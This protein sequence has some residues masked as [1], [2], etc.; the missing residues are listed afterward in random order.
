M[1]LRLPERLRGNYPL[2]KRVAAPVNIVDVFPTVLQLA[3]AAP[4]NGLPGVSLLT[5]AR[6]RAIFSEYHAQGM[7]N[8]GYMLKYG[9]YKLCY[10]VN[11][12][13]Q[14]F[15]LSN[16]PEETHDLHGAGQYGSV[17]KA[18]TGMLKSVCDPEKRDARA[19]RNQQNR[20]A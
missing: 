10:Y 1:I 18:M 11:G 19:K 14:L 6:D 5:P 3:G 4:V 12:E 16:D 15:D 7:L 2:E 20:L 13:P 8:A 9:A 17:E